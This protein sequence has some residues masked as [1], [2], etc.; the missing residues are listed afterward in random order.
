MSQQYNLKCLVKGEHG[1]RAITMTIKF[2]INYKILCALAQDCPEDNCF[3]F[4]FYGRI[5]CLY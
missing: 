1:R 4:Q 3:S 5:F 2:K